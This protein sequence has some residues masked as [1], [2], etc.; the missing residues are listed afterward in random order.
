M[1]RR[2]SLGGNNRLAENSVPKLRLEGCRRD[3]IDAV[4]DEFPKSPLKAHE[5]KE[6]DRATEFDEQIDVTILASLVA[7]ERAEQRHTSNAEGVQDRTVVA[8]R[9]QDVISLD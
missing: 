9:L 6:S 7:R 5:L 4:A 3:K 1:R 8:Q 2:H